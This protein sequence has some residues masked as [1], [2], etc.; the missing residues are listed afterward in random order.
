LV[1]IGIPA[2]AGLSVLHGLVLPHPDPLAAIATVKADLGI[3]LALGLLVAVPTVIV[4]GPVF[5][6]LAARWV[7]AAPP[8]EPTAGTEE[9]AGSAEDAD[10]RRPGFGLT[11]GTVLLPVVLMLGR[12]VADIWLDKEDTA[13]TMLSV[14]RFSPCSSRSSSRCSHLG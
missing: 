12:A 6:R 9:T 5:G 8:P 1:L 10:R 3:T 4:A 7:D 2:L 14:N 13:R 11:I